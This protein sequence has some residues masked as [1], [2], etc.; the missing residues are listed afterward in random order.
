MLLDLLTD[1]S[2]LDVGNLVNR[3]HPLAE[4]LLSWWLVLPQRTGGTRWVDL[5]NTNHATLNGISASPSLTSGWS[6]TTMRP[7]GFGELRL[8]GTGDYGSVADS[9][10]FTFGAGRPF[11]IGCW[12]WITNIAS[13]QGVV[14]KWTTNNVTAEW[15]VYTSGSMFAIE[16]YAVGTNMY[17]RQVALTTGA[18][19]GMW[20]RWLCTSAG[21]ATDAT[22]AIYCDGRRVDT[23]NAGGTNG[24]AMADSTAVV[25][26]GAYGG[27]ANFLTGK[28]DDIRIWGR[29]LS[30]AQALADY[31]TSR[32]GYPDLLNR[33]PLWP[34]TLSGSNFFGG[35]ED[36]IWYAHVD[37]A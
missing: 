5:V 1:A 23:T 17:G 36:G 14:S 32:Q 26:F 11:T 35:D 6:R 28:L 3:Q 20:H 24:T 15:I 16:C 4:G 29:Q 34:G 13:T 8:D 19:Q 22:L 18:H 21:A 30:P 9:P 33:L 10:R 7:G 31:A 37:A 2:F 27:A 12:V 25:A